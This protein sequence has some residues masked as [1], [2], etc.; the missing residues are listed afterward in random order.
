[1]SD[2]E[3]VDFDFF[4]TPRNEE[5]HGGVSK[6]SVDKQSHYS[7]SGSRPE[8]HG[9][10]SNGSYKRERRY[11]YE[12]I[13]S[14]NSNQRK[15]DYSDSFS[16]DSDTESETPRN[17]K[18]SSSNK[19]QEETSKNKKKYKSESSDESSSA[20]SNSDFESDDSLSDD[21][22]SNKEK[23]DIRMPNP[24]VNAWENENKAP[25]HADE[26]YSKKSKKVVSDDSDSDIDE[27]RN[28]NRNVRNRVQSAKRRNQGN[29]SNDKRSLRSRSS[30]YSNNSDITD[31]SPLDSPQNSPRNSRK[32]YEK[33]VQY[34]I[35]SPER[36]SNIKLETD[37]IDLSILMKCMEDIDREKQQRI[38]NNSR[39]VAFASSSTL[40]DK[41]KGNYTFSV[42]RAKIIEK[43]NQRLLKQ[44]MMQ[45]N[46]GGGTTKKIPSKTTK[47]P[48]RATQPVVQR[49]TPSAVNRMK[50]QKRI[51]QENMQLLSRLHTT[52]PTRG[53]SRME[54]IEDAE[55]IMSYGLP[56]GTT[57][58][59]GDTYYEPKPYRVVHSS[60][61]HTA[62]STQRS[63]PSSAK[64]NASMV[65]PGKR[66]R[67]SSAKSNAS[68]VSN[69]SMR[70]NASKRSI[71]SNASS[72]GVRRMADGRIDR[73]PVWDDRFSFS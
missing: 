41:P 31:V 25:E 62:G 33:H 32:Q 16:D 70:S 72:I 51:E 21:Q 42:G 20:Y 24:K 63:R 29:G 8:K 34:D 68:I 60:M 10:V 57:M 44:I 7:T 17:E 58:M 49:L 9:G 30:S 38:K 48:K 37:Q 55:R 19:K 35:D 3:E 15:G 43:E 4:E 50:E 47:G 23:I 56:L 69:A 39:R 66:S 45:M 1:M 27:K 65:M 5:N 64:S 46:G 13:V 18:R 71:R 28:K 59:P 36:D 22:S 73:R 40:G 11:S 52:R 26:K 53:M 54:Q 2:P 6:V 67:P 61:S 12:K 14:K